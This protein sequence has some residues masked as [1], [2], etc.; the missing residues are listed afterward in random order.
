MS[1][2]ILSIYDLIFNNVVFVANFKSILQF[3]KIPST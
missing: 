2:D 1:V 3:L